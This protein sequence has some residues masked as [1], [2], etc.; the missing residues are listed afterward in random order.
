MSIPVTSR[1]KLYTVFYRSSTDEVDSNSNGGQKCMY[2]LF[3]L[4]IFL[5]SLR[6]K[7]DTVAVRIF[8]ASLSRSPKARK[9]QA[10]T[11]MAYITNIL[12]LTNIWCGV[13]NMKACVMLHSPV[14]LCFP[15]LGMKY[16]CVML[17]NRFNKQCT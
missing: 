9:L 12:V 11:P 8:T 7:L 4:H 15:S 17:C 6:H 14:S 3:Y 13:Q 1:P 10:R 5:S 16:D 2:G